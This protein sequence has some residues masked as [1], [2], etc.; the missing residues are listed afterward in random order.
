MTPAT[1]LSSTRCTSA[2]EGLL[3]RVLADLVAICHFLFIAFVLAGG[4]LVIRWRAVAWVHLPLR[5]R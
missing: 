1:G 4:V 3:Y 2:E 5:A